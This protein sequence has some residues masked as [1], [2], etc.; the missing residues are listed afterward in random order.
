MFLFNFKV[1]DHRYDVCKGLLL[2][3]L[4]LAILDWQLVTLPAVLY[5]LYYFLRAFRLVGKY[6][7]A[8]GNRVKAHSS[9]EVSSLI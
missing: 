8:A 1:M 5:P 7:A 9:H 3:V 4:I 2:S 6:G